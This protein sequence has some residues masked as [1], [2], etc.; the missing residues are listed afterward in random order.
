MFIQQ[1]LTTISFINRSTFFYTGF[2]LLP[3]ADLN[4]FF[5]F[6]GCFQIE[7]FV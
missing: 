3:L 2:C 7:P 6:F 4:S 5:N 1:I